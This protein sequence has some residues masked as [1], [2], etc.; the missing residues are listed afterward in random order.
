MRQGLA[1]GPAAQRPRGLDPSLFFF[2]LG[3][4]GWRAVVG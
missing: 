3:I 2:R 1:T 4:P